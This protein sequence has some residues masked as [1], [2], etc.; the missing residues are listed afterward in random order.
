MSIP[1][2]CTQVLVY[3]LQHAWVLSMCQQLC[4][5]STGPAVCAILLTTAANPLAPFWSECVF[6]KVL[7][8]AL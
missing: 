2:S 8:G 1:T 7:T 3:T 5:W 6:A 4:A